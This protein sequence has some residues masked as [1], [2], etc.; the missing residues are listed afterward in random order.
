MH[1]LAHHALAAVDDTL[2]VDLAAVV[3]C[4]L[5]SLVDR[6]HHV[7]ALHERLQSRV[8]SS[9]DREAAALSRAIGRAVVLGKV[10]GKAFAICLLHGFPVGLAV[11]FELC[12]CRLG[13][14]VDSRT[15]VIG[16][17]RGLLRYHHRIALA[18]AHGHPIALVK[19][20]AVVAA[21]L[22]GRGALV[23]KRAVSDIGGSLCILVK[24]VDLEVDRGIGLVG[25]NGHRAQVHVLIGLEDVGRVDGAVLAA[26][27]HRAV[28]HEVVILVHYKHV[29][30]V[31]ARDVK[32]VGLGHA[33]GFVVVRDPKVARVLAV[34]V[35]DAPAAGKVLAVIAVAGLGP[36]AVLDQPSAVTCGCVRCRA[37]L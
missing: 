13:L 11:G 17:V 32:V 4:L 21:V 34:V 18:F 37:L 29:V 12:V 35:H 9:L 28:R 16:A 7:G 24:Q 36:P 8:D 15:L 22:E 23:G 2:E 20:E 5:Y 30:V 10:L 1:D 3:F 27:D 26:V 14:A 25:C 19:M 6:G 31:V 33:E